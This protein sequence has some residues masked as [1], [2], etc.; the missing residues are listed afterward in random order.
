MPPSVFYSPNWPKLSTPSL[1]RDASS[2]GFVFGCS[3][4]DGFGTRFGITGALKIE[5][6]KARLSTFSLALPCFALPTL[7]TLL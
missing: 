7:S 5:Y 4:I 2:C 3:L 6:T 1:S